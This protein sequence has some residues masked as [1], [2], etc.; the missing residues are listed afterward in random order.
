MDREGGQE[1]GTKYAQL[2]AA[3]Y[4]QEQASQG[5][6]VP[7]R[8]ET[9]NCARPLEPDVDRN[10]GAVLRC[11]RCGYVM[12]EIPEIVLL[13]WRTVIGRASDA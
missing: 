10:G 6:C 2:L 9:E 8:C 4:W 13:L 1:T 7:L 12:E 11:D 5:R 3:R